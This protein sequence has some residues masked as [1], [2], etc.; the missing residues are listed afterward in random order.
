MIICRIYK[1]FHLIY[2]LFFTALNSPVTQ[3]EQQMPSRINMN[4]EEE[5][6]EEEEE[7][8]E[9]VEEEVEEEEVEEEKE[10]EEYYFVCPLEQYAMNELAYGNPFDDKYDDIYRKIK[11]ISSNHIDCFER[12]INELD[13]TIIGALIYSSGIN[14]NFLRYLDKKYSLKNYIDSIGYFNTIEKIKYF[15]EE[16]GLDFDKK[17][18]KTCDDFECIK[19]AL[20]NGCNYVKWHLKMRLYNFRKEIEKDEW[21]TEFY[22]NINIEE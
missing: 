18:L 6:V 19:Y 13:E 15:K 22:K 8:E 14:I 5:E 7:E 11:C 1:C 12:Y 20:Q 4:E 17:F 3:K 16:I 2:K 21:M 9:E 10:E